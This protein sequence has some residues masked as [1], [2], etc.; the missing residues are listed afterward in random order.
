[1]KDSTWKI[2]FG[3]I[4]DDKNKVVCTLPNNRENNN[5]AKLI[6]AAPMLLPL[7]Y[8]A[9]DALI[10]HGDETTEPWIRKQINDLNL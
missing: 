4:V 3:K 2:A 6:A 5:Q 7:L 1:M 9:L 10:D 8:T